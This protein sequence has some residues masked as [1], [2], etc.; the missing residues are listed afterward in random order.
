MINKQHSAKRYPVAIAVRVFQ[1]LNSGA[2]KVNDFL[3]RS[4]ALGAI[5]R[6]QHRHMPLPLPLFDMLFR[7]RVIAKMFSSYG[8][9]VFHAGYDQRKDDYWTSH[10]C[11]YHHLWYQSQPWWDVVEGF[12]QE[13]EIRSFLLRGDL[14]FFEPGF[15]LGRT[16]RALIR[17]GILR[18][19]N[20]YATEP[21][22]Y[23]RDY[24]RKRFGKQLGDSFE[25][26]PGK[27]QDVVASDLRFDAL[28]VF[29]GVLMYLPEDTLTAFF[30][31]LPHRGCRYVLIG[32]D[33][34]PG[35]KLVRRGEIT[36]YTKATHYDLLPRLQ[37]VY[38]KARF[39]SKLDHDGAYQYTCVLAD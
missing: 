23:L 11:I 28:L 9:H 17:R 7:N 34:S 31:S 8:S 30:A 25:I 2:N 27:I 22:A 15:G 38:P 13:P 4:A 6:F 21:N 20:Y 3:S 14:T 10:E 32:R 35:G 5:V 12:L 1:T 19:R 37:A 16:T 24:F 36:P 29:G 33:G 39:F 26:H 18:W